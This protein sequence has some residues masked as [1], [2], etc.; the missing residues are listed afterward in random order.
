[1]SMK[2]HTQIDRWTYKRVRERDGGCCI[3]CGRPWYLQCA[4]YIGRAQ[5]GKG[6]P[7]NLVM[8]CAKCHQDYDN[9]AMRNDYGMAIRDYLK[10]WYPNWNEADLVYDKYEW[11]KVAQDEAESETTD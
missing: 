2:E 7:Q 1:M 10:S 5:G 4:H 9:G 11:L 3:L 8:L 6:I